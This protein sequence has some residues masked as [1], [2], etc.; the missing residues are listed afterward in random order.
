MGQLDVGN[1]SPVPGYADH[2]PI[3]P[4][5]VEQNPG[6]AARLHCLSK[7]AAQDESRAVMANVPVE[8]SRLDADDLD[9][10]PQCVQGRRKRLT[11][12]AWLVG[13]DNAGVSHRKSP[14]GTPA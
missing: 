13:H 7:P 11:V 4:I 3:L 5:R 9:V 8:I 10:W 6:V 1:E 14:Q 2:C 12:R